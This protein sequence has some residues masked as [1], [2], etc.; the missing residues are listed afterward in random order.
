MK[1]PFENLN[2]DS[3]PS[4]QEFCTCRVTITLIVYNKI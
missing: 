3:Y 2:P 1:L 4:S